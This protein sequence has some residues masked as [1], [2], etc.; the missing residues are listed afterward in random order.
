MTGRRLAGVLCL[1]LV[2]CTSFEPR[3]RAQAGG[4]DA[5]PSFKWVDPTPLDPEVARR[6]FTLYDNGKYEEFDRLLAPL[7]QSVTNPFELDADA[8]AWIQASPE[9]NRRGL[10]A[11]TV[12]LELANVQRGAH[13]WSLELAELGCALLRELPPTASE[14][15]WHEA[16]IALSR[17]TFSVE[18]IEP[19]ASAP[20]TDLRDVERAKQD[21]REYRSMAERLRLVAAR[22]SRSKRLDDITLDPHHARHMAARFPNDPLLDLLPAVGMELHRVSLTDTLF[23]TGQ[24]RWL[25]PSEVDRIAKAG[26]RQIAAIPPTRRMDRASAEKLLAIVPEPQPQSRDRVTGRDPGAAATSLQL[27]DIADAFRSLAEREGI[28]A[29]ANVRLG[30]T[31]IQLAQPASALGA[32]A[33]AEQVARTPYDTYLAHLLAGATLERLGRRA[34]AMTAFRDALRAVPRAQSAA[35]ALAPFLFETGAR[36][37]AADLLQSAVAA[38]L[39]PDPLQFYFLGDPDAS[40]RALARLREAL[41]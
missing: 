32:F 31:Y 26:R 4:G 27:W 9:R 40:V 39:T 1:V 36:D 19:R 3:I 12:A 30:M 11:A 16:F 2:T 38:P 10:V 18:R 35:F 23:P 41:R 5:A 37:E 6:L 8:D 22:T 13:L 7:A 34:D 20:A 25:D 24:P 17:L 29:E 28:A 14:R 21:R 15:S 33:R